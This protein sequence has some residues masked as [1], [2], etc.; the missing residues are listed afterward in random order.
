MADTANSIGNAMMATK[1]DTIILYSETD[2]NFFKKPYSW[3]DDL[4]NN[5]LFNVL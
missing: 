4:L 3:L 1:A 2:L 5:S